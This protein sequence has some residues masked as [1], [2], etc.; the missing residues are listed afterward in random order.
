MGFVVLVAGW[1]IGGL[2]CGGGLGVG[3]GDRCAVSVAAVAVLLKHCALP[4]LE[5]M[6]LDCLGS[7]HNQGSSDFTASTVIHSLSRPVIFFSCRSFNLYTPQNKSF[8]CL[9]RNRTR[10]LYIG[11]RRARFTFLRPKT[12]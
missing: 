12:S 2:T 4:W 8:A 5:A 3:E 6:T 10:Q 1:P 11:Q 9:L 7:S